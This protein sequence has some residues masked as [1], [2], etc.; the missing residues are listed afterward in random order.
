VHTR[1]SFNLSRLPHLPNSFSVPLNSFGSVNSISFT[2]TDSCSNLPLVFL[3]AESS[4]SSV[5]PVSSWSIRQSSFPLSRSSLRSIRQAQNDVSRVSSPSRRFSTDSSVHTPPSVSYFTSLPLLVFPVS[6]K[7]V[8]TFTQ[9]SSFFAVRRVSFSRNS[10]RRFFIR[11]RFVGSSARRF[12]QSPVLVASS[13]NDSALTASTKSLTAVDGTRYSNSWSFGF[14][15]SN[16][17][18][19]SS[20]LALLTGS[21]VHLTR[22]PALSV[23]RFAHDRETLLYSA[24]QRA[25]RLGTTSSPFTSAYPYS[26]A[27]SSVGSTAS[28][29]SNP[30]ITPLSSPLAVFLRNRHRFSFR[31]ET[32]KLFSSRALSAVSSSS[33]PLSGFVF[34][35][36]LPDSRA[37]T[38]RRHSGTPYAVLPRLTSAALLRTLERS[39]G[40]FQRTAVH[41][42]DLLRLG[43]IAR[44][45]KK[46][47]LLA[48]LFS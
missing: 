4:F 38:N 22:V 2:P 42:P 26:S 8:P 13:A 27:A 34:S 35:T 46:A 11:R 39:R 33:S 31:S 18:A 20:T 1:Y 28:V 3:K 30:A 21:S 25:S 40:R 12:R 14:S 6:S 9:A 44:Y 36:A 43:F 47:D 19:I 10:L 17:A 48:A 15:R 37:S 7:Q 23:A 32:S 45:F 5:R 16:H 41:L 29:F 24:T